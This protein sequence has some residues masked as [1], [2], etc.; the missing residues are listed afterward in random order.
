M[1]LTDGG[2]DVQGLLDLLDA[3]VTLEG[4][5]GE[6]HGKSYFRLKNL[7]KMISTAFNN[8]KEKGAVQP[9]EDSGSESSE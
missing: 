7:N 9:A 1:Q 5:V 2:I 8:Y 3:E 4:S 6:W